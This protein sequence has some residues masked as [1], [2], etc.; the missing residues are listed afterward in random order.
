VVVAAKAE[1]AVE[2]ELVA[3]DEDETVSD[4]VVF[5]GVVDAV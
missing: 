4:G 3:M 1:E 2:P 5:D